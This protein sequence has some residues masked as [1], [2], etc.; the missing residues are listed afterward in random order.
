MALYLDTS[1][2][3]KLFVNE[4]DSDKVEKAVDADPEVFVG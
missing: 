1:A 4:S 3:V 2:L